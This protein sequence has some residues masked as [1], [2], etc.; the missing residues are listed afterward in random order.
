[1]SGTYPLDLAR[2]HSDGFTDT[3]A[4][5]FD[6]LAAE[7]LNGPRPARLFDIGCGDGTWLATTRE[8]GVRGS[9]VDLSPAFVELAWARGLDVTEARAAEVTIP[10][11]TTASAALG[12]V[13]SYIDTATET[14]SLVA[15]LDMAWDALPPGDILTGDLIGRGVFPTAGQPSGPDWH[16]R[17]EVSV[18]ADRVSR[19][20]ETIYQGKVSTVTHHQ[21]RRDPEETL[22]LV[23]DRGWK[24]SLAESY[25]PATLLPGRFALW[26]TRP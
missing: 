7:I 12:E 9:G 6:W 10:G 25:G 24:C 4:T 20:I 17:S 26:M 14:D 15:V 8:R 11:G 23:R 19:R 2:I 5:G 22:A 16:M 21:S 13:L 1:M 3:F 18:T